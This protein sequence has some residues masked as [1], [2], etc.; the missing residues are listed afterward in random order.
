MATTGVRST[1]GYQNLA[2]TGTEG[3]SGGDGDDTL[4]A[5][6]AES[7]QVHLFGGI[8]DDTFILDLT[9]NSGRQGHHAYGGEGSDTFNFTNVHLVNSPVVGRLNDFEPSRDVIKIEGQVIDLKNLPSTIA[10]TDG[11]SIIVR[12]VEHMS[13]GT[14][15]SADVLGLGPQHFLQIGDNVFYALDGARNGG[16][17]HHFI[18]VPSPSDL[19]EVIYLNEVNFVPFDFYDD[20]DLR[21]RVVKH[22][23]DDFNGW[24]ISEYIRGHVNGNIDGEASG[25]HETIF[26][27]NGNDIVDGA[28]GDDLIYG[29]NGNDLIAGGI[30]HDTLHGELGNDRLWGGSGNDSLIGGDGNDTL[31]GGSGNDTLKGGSGDDDIFGGNQDDLIY[32]NGGADSLLGGLGDDEIRG[33]SHDDTLHGGDGA[34]ILKGENGNDLLYGE[35]GDDALSGANGNDTILGGE[36]DDKLYGR[37]DNDLLEGDEGDDRIQGD[38][39]ND[40][41]WGG[42]GADRFVF[43]DGDGSDE[44]GDFNVSEIGEV[45]DLSDISKITSFTDLIANHATDVGPD[46]VIDTGGGNQFRIY[47]VLMADLSADDFVF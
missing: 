27:D 26:A 44:I 12:V 13:T 6:V 14:S 8:G 19:T 1:G 22:S 35:A 9:N 37:A 45:I 30:D 42:S 5:S 47:D 28:T 29:G 39:G 38:G 25:A 40:T 21:I 17:E 3:L 36:G 46:L 23:D 7:G 11:S 18:N 20:L 10:L 41:M 34:D 31:D 43:K 16:T 2:A 24:K 33:G 15:N 32:G 4:E